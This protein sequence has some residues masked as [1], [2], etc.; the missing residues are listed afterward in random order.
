MKAK[1]LALGALAALLAL[2]A[3]AAEPPPGS[4]HVYRPALRVPPPAPGAATMLY[5]AGPVISSVKVAVVFWGTGVAKITTSRIGPFFSALVDS[6]YVDQLAQYSTNITG[7]NGR[8]GTDQTIARGSYLGAFRITPANTAKTLTD[9][10]LHQEIRAQIAS[11]ALPAQ[12][13]DTLYMIYFPANITITIDKLV[14]C[15]DFGA[16]HEAKSAKLSDKN[17]YYGVMPDCGGGFSAITYA[18][19]HE[20]AEAVT[21]AIPTPGSHPAFPQAWNTADGYEIGDLCEGDSTTLTA[22]G[23]TY[24]VTEVFDNAKNACGTGKFSSP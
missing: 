3:V 24:V 5:Y 1:C 20:F 4:Y 7:V 15:V 22:A 9:T 18:S 10:E 14:S 2:P 17:I 21:D 11:G 19:S 13:T 8:R 23:K 16:Y 6:T 12:D